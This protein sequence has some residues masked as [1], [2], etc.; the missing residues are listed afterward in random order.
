MTT[1]LIKIMKRIYVNSSDFFIPITTI[2]KYP[3]LFTSLIQRIKKI[4]ECYSLLKYDIKIQNLNTD[5]A[6]AQ[7]ELSNKGGVYVLWCKSTGM[8]YV[9]SAL[10]FF[11]NKGRLT[12][13]FMPGR[14]K[15]SLEGNSTKVSKDLASAIFTYGIQ[16]FTLLIP[17]HDI[18]SKLDK[19]TIQGWEQ[20]WMMLNPTLNRS[21]MVSSNSGTMMSEEDRMKISTMFYQYEIDNN[22]AI[23]PNTEKILFGLKETS[24]IGITSMDNTHY[25]IQ[26]DTLKGH[27]DNKMIWVTSQHK[28]YF[29]AEPLTNYLILSSVNVNTDVELSD[30]R[31]RGIWVYDANTKEFISYESSVKDCEMKYNISRTHLK[32]VRKYNQPY[33][34]K[35][36]SNHKL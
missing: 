25:P 22:N 11:T 30:K 23:I 4:Q 1:A 9:G 19:A 36:F 21:L 32:R 17:Q 31:S 5:K 28:F 34:G 14:V 13:Y 6:K 26:Y 15:A 33:Q 29:S 12:D 18:S 8:F 24:R 7:N 35:L 16:D 10:R 27:F 2:T 20:L 3:I